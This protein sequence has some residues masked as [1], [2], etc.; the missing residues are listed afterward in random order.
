[1]KGAFSR[2]KEK[3]GEWGNLIKR[4]GLYLVVFQ[5]GKCLMSEPY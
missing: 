2:G 1:M 3:I 5:I 4:K